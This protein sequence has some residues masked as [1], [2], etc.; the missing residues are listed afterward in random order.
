MGTTNIMIQPMPRMS[1]CTPRS[2]GFCSGRRMEEYLPIYSPRW[3]QLCL[4]FVGVRDHVVYCL[5]NFV[6]ACA[7]TQ[8]ACN[9]LLDLIACWVRFLFQQ[10]CGRHQETRRAVSALHCTMFDKC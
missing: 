9:R 8:I 7:T 5:N 6:V 1:G 2:R 10:F 4:Y 3:I